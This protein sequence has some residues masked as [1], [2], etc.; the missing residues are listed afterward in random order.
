VVARTS[1]VP[2]SHISANA[3][4]AR[5]AGVVLPTHAPANPWGRECRSCQAVDFGPIC[6]G[7]TAEPVHAA[8]VLGSTVSTRS[9]QPYEVESAVSVPPTSVLPAPALLHEQPLPDIATRRE[10]PGGIA[11]QAA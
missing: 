7:L 5:T 3:A 8:E 11:G 2:A 9:S 1:G 10:A 4:L 6:S